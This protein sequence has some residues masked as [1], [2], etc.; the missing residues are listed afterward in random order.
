MREWIEAQ[1]AAGLPALKGSAVSGTLAVK[2]ELINEF[3]AQWLA[4]GARRPG[5]GAAPAD[6]GRAVGFIKEAAV[7]A[8]PGTLLVDFKIAV[9]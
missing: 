1:L 6:V 9:D 4:E 5:G 2:Q 7:R 8:E 3:L